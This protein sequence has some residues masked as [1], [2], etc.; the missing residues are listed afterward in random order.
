MADEIHLVDRQYQLAQVEQ[1][2]Y[3]GMPPCRRVWPETPGARID[4]EDRGVG[5]RGA[6]VL[7]A[8]G[9]GR[10]EFLASLGRP[11]I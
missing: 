4:D 7:K 9:K 3:I 2:Q 10:A 8:A 6:L 11:K 1:A 5:R